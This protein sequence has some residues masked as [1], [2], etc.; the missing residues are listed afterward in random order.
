MML[1]IGGGGGGGGALASD[2]RAPNRARYS[3]SPSPRR[4]GG[5]VGGGQ[6]HAQDRVGP[7]TLFAGGPVQVDERLVDLVLFGTIHP[8]DVVGDLAVDRRHRPA[9]APSPGNGKDRRRGPRG[10]RGF[11]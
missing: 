3:K 1:T 5:G 9:H 4:A 11:R 6:R 8:D 10:P 2:R 7:E